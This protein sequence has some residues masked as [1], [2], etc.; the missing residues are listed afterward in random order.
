MLSD[1]G[2]MHWGSIEET[3]VDIKKKKIP[4]KPSLTRLII[5]HGTCQR[6]TKL[7]KCS[8]GLIVIRNPSGVVDTSVMREHCDRQFPELRPFAGMFLG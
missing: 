3:H 7:D 4:N 8:L 1:V 5:A 6:F 2:H